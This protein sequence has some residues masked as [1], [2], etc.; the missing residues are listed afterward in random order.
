MAIGSFLLVFGLLLTLF[1]GS[2][3]DELNL[4]GFYN[5]E[6]AI[7]YSQLAGM[8]V[9]AMGAGFLAFGY[10]INSESSREINRVNDG[11]TA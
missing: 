5:Y 9:A 11:L 1:S 7:A 6:A 4:Y 3:F 8:I 10:G 2:L